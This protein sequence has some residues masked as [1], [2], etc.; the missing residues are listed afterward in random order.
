MVEYS[1]I[2]CNLTNVQLNKLKKLL[3]LIKEQ[4]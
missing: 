4:H 3:N 1:D 2:I